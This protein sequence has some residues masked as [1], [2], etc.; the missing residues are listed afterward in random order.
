MSSAPVSDNNSQNY[1]D[2]WTW[3]WTTPVGPHFWN[4]KWVQIPAEQGSEI[5]E[6]LPAAAQTPEA[7]TTKIQ[8]IL[9]AVQAPTT[10]VAENQEPL[11]DGFFNLSAADIAELELSEGTIAEIEAE[12][13]AEFLR[14]E[15]S[16]LR[17]ERKLLHERRREEDRRA[18][19]KK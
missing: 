14:Q 12:E 15:E 6:I 7:Q 2:G 13:Y 5:Q 10:P 3:E 18:A 1:W 16:R 19:E 11:D 9:P 8:E 4:W 17:R